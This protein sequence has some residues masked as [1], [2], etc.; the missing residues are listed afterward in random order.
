MC[1]HLY[2]LVASSSPVVLTVSLLFFGE[3]GA[4]HPSRI[5]MGVAPKTPGGVVSFS[6]SRDPSGVREASQRDYLL[7]L[8]ISPWVV[9]SSD[10]GG[11][12]KKRMNTHDKTKKRSNYATG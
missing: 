2:L 7:L 12:G 9:T 11:E 5:P 3:E 10:S 4:W 1:V 8:G 6:F